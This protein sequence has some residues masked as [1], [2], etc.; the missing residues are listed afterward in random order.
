MVLGEVLA[1]T[2]T[3]VVE[4]LLCLRVVFHVVCVTLVCALLCVLRVFM[5]VVACFC[6]CVARFFKMC[7]M[8]FTQALFVR[9]VG[10]FSCWFPCACLRAV[11]VFE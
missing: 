7:V 3:A 9:V 4:I 11:C 1:K 5:R 8:V 2:A 10:V 6:V